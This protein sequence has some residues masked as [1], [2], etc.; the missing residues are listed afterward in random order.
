MFMSK[1]TRI[2]DATIEHVWK[3]Y[4]Q[5]MDCAAI[6]MKLKISQAS[7]LRCITAMCMASTGRLVEYTGLLKD[8]HHI[9]DYA[10]QRFGLSVDEPVSKEA[11]DLATA[12]QDLAA[13]ITRQTNV[14]EGFIRK[15]EK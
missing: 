7:V 12:I 13:A 9:A 14:F 6:A 8:S 4:E 11:D 15:L 5:G 3:L 10:N 2:T 1:R